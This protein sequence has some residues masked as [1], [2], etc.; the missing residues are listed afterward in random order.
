MPLTRSGH[1][2]RNTAAAAARAHEG[3]ATFVVLVKGDIAAAIARLAREHAAFEPDYR[4]VS[5]LT[6]S[7]HGIC[8]PWSSDVAAVIVNTDGVVCT[9]LDERRSMNGAWIEDAFVRSRRFGVAQLPDDHVG[10]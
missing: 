6:E 9:W 4:R 3:T 5:D 1:A 10:P 7:V 2:P 8:M